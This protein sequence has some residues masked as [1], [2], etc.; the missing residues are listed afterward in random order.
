MCQPGR[1]GSRLFNP[2]NRTLWLTAFLY[3]LPSYI[4]IAGLP[5]LPERPIVAHAMHRER[6]GGDGHA[7]FLPSLSW[8]S[9][10]CARGWD[11]CWPAVPSGETQRH[12]PITKAGHS[13]T[14]WLLSQAAVSI[15]RRRPPQTEELRT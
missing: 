2:L 7:S 1:S 3:L 4:A 5:G 6:S 10:P 8:D 15:L 14:R 11:G 12:G 13:R 9:A